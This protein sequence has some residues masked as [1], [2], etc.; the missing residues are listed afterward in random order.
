[1]VSTAG[2]GQIGSEF[3]YHS[4]YFPVLKIAYTL[5]QHSS[6]LL[7]E[8]LT[9]LSFSSQTA[10]RWGI[11]WKYVQ[12]FVICWRSPTNTAVS[13]ILMTFNVVRIHIASSHSCSTDV[14][15]ET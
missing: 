11:L 14:T 1:M 13:G 3:T 12:T 4:V 5:K 7:Y 8:I 9:A 15:T 2:F 10:R 6:N